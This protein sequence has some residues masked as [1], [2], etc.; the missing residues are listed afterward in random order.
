MMMLTVTIVLISFHKSEL[1]SSSPD[2]VSRL[3]E[4]TFTRSAY[5]N[6]GTKCPCAV[7]YYSVFHMAETCLYTVADS[8]RK[9]SVRKF[10]SRTYK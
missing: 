8:D 9:V 4:I 5:K 1:L 2:P 7:L 6:T 10:A 3:L